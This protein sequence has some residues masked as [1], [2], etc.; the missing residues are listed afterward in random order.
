MTKQGPHSRA[1]LDPAW[2]GLALSRPNKVCKVIAHLGRFEPRVAAQ[3]ERENEAAFAAT[4]RVAH[5]VH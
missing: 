1:A 2:Y 5:A 3:F 4:G